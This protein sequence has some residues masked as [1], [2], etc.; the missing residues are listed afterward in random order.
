MPAR[1]TL[2]ASPSSLDF[3][4]I[5]VGGGGTQS[6]TLTNSGSS[7]VTIFQAAITGEG[8]GL[9]GLSLPVSLGQG[10]SV[11]F[12]VTFTPKVGGDTSGAIDVVSN[13]VNPNLAVALSGTGVSAGQLTSS[14]GALDF[15]NV[16]VGTSKAIT[17]TL[18]AGGS[19]VT[20]TSATSTSAEFQLAG[21]SLPTTLAA[22]QSVPVSLTFTPQ[23]S[24]AASG[25]ISLISNAA[26]TPMIET[27]SGSG[28]AATS[29]HT[30]SLRWIRQ[31]F[32][33]GG[34]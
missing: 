4:N 26:N 20:I 6:Q 15:G 18:S 14:A 33:G 2:A 17:A 11:T 29:S 10:E 3:G 16:A 23:S 30:V 1:T 25:S 8:F 31:P 12:S 32:A 9:S 24:G 19:S 5:Q 28:T 27:L 21:L 34:V 22:G 7:T 13:A